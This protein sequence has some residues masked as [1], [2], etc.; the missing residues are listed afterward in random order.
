MKVKDLRRILGEFPEDHEILIADYKYSGPFMKVFKVEA[1][2]LV[3]DR[4]K[5]YIVL[6]NDNTPS[7]RKA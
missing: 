6:L 2:Y 3:C 5:K 4:S 7:E 1:G